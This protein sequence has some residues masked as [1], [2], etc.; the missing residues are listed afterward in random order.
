VTMPHKRSEKAVEY[1]VQLAKAIEAFVSGKIKSAYTAEKEY[2]VSRSVI[3]RQMKSGVSRTIEYKQEQILFSSEE[4][5]LFLWCKRLTAGGFPA[6]HQVVREMGNEI[7]A[8]CIVQINTDGIDYINVPTIEKD[9]TKRFIQRYPTLKSTMARRIDALRWKDTTPEVVNAWF[10]AFSDVYSTHNFEPHNVYN[11]E[12]TGFGIGTSQSC[13][14]IIDSTLR[15]RYKLEPGQQEWVSIVEC[16]SADG[17]VLPPMI[18]FQAKNVSNTW[19]TESTPYN[20]QFSTSL[21]DWTS[22]IHD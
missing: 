3:G 20:W 5:V 1:E 22:N 7:L 16:I 14:V 15:T 13:R 9:W 17:E 10:D 12:K 21:K 18:I 8:R 6:H 4:D 2:G 11:M 19:I